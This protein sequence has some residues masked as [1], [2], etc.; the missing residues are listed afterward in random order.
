MSALSNNNCAIL[1]LFGY[2][3]SSRRCDIILGRTNTKY[4]CVY[5]PCPLANAK[6]SPL[7]FFL[8]IFQFSHSLHWHVQNVTIPCH[9]QKLLPFHS[10]MYFFLPP[11][12]TN[13]S[14]ILSHLILPSISWSTSQSCCSQNHI[15]YPVGNPISSTLYTCPN[16]RN[17]F[18]LIVS[19]IVGF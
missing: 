3:H 8:F 2:K 6:Y 18:N 14:S 5:F 4:T 19:V 7:Q 1:K 12:S 17:L 15:Q 10:V 9:S 16:Q 11:F 13:Y